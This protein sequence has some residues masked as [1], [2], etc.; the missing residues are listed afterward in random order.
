VSPPP[1]LRHLARLTD[2]VGIVEHA[3]GRDPAPALGHC[4]DD[5]GRALALASRLADDPDA[6]R[7]AQV[8]LRFLRGAPISGGWF[9][10][11][12]RDGWAGHSDDSCGRAVYGLA[13]AV[14]RAPWDEVA[15]P[16][17]ELLDVAIGFRSGHPRAMAYA[18][19][20]AA[21]LLAVEPGH[22]GARSLLGDALAALPR[23]ST[24]ATWR[25]P[26]PRLTYANA[27]LPDAL[28]AAGVAL[29]HPTAVAQALDL[30]SWLV[31]EESV[32]DHFSFVPVGGRGP[33]DPKPAFDQQPIEA[34]VMCAACAR[35]F[36]V[37][38]APRWAASARR[39]AA[40]F[41]GGNDVGVALWDPETD[42]CHDGLEAHDVNRNE[43]AEST[44]AL[45]E[46]AVAV[47]GLES[48]ELVS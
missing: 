13:V 12:H 32:D 42:G 46:A 37:T 4:T 47:A 28:L 31:E 41:T 2:A 26:F 21:E 8:A 7:I 43:G 38:G 1:S 19:V 17:A 35:A 30:L 45:A 33:G 6:R 16:A 22:A 20:G 14:A 3:R 27:L 24:D 5:A 11:R 39:A 34:A 23:P 9:A 48:E 15:G 36:A 44:M 18:T 40:W 10:L 29:D 25:W